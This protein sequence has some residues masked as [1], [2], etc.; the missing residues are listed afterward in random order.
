MVLYRTHHL[1]YP[2]VPLSGTL[3]GLDNRNGTSPA[4]A[5]YASRPSGRRRS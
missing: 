5:P 3:F 2:L 1:R 4:G